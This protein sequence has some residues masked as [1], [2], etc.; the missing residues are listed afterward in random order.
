MKG[1]LSW[2]ELEF[3][4]TLPRMSALNNRI[5]TE[6]TIDVLFLRTP[7]PLPWVSLSKLIR[8]FFVDDIVRQGQTKK[9]SMKTLR[10]Q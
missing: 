5:S 2:R 4:D 8:N 7:L 10:R 3:S 1:H 9:I 6:I